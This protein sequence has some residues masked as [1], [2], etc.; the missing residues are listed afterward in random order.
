MKVKWSGIG[1][2]EGR[3]KLNGSV[4]SRNRGGAYF[5]VKVT[6]T[7]PQSIAQQM[8]RQL[9]TTFSQGWRALTQD[10]RSAWDAATPDFA[11]S[12]IFGDMRNPTGKNLYARL[13]VNLSNAGQAAITSPPLPSGAGDVLASGLTFSVATD[14]EVTAT[15]PGAGFTVLVFATPGVSPGKRFLKNDF[16]LLGNVAGSSSSPLDIAAMYTARFGVPAIGTRVGVRLV[17]VNNLTGES[18]VPSEANT[19]VVA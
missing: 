16:R 10:Q 18:S 17:S 4:A 7:N 11:R 6:P 1:A 3:G 13:N 19:L 9:L 2:V 5:R 14:K 15:M 8:V 12:D